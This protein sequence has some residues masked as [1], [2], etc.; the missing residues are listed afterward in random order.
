M[1][2]FLFLS[3][4][5]LIFGFLVSVVSLKKRTFLLASVFSVLCFLS[6]SLS[7]FSGLLFIDHNAELAQSILYASFSGSLL[8]D[9][10]SK[11][12]ETKF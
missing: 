12:E 7:F 9:F 2:T 8:A 10:P 5:S 3:L 11:R 4:V 1:I 6:M